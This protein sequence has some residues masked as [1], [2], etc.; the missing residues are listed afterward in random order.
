MEQKC[1]EYKPH[2]ILQMLRPSTQ[3]KMRKKTV[4]DHYLITEV[5]DYFDS[6]SASSG[7]NFPSS[8]AKA[9]LSCVNLMKT[10]Y[11]ELNIA[12]FPPAIP[13]FATKKFWLMTRTKID[14][15]D[16]LMQ[17]IHIIML[18]LHLCQDSI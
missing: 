18:E 15:W 14:G 8:A 7:V 10:N 4:W 1:Q 11:I 9:S 13:T 5:H 2:A 16:F 17:G 12:F 3:K 6:T